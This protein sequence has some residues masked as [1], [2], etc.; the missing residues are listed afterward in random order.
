[1]F[2]NI[3][4]HWNKKSIST[5]GDIF[6]GNTPSKKHPEYYNEASVLWVKPSDLSEFKP[7]I[8]DTEEKLS[9]EGSKKARILPINSVLVTC[10]GSIGKVGMAP[11]ELATNQQINAVSFDSSQVIPKF[12]YYI[13]IYS[14][15]LLESAASKAVVPILN[16]TQF[17]NIKIPVPPTLQE[18]EEIVKIL[19]DAAALVQARKKCIE[20]TEELTP[21]IFYEMFGD[22]VSNPNK[23]SVTK[24]GKICKVE[25]GSTPSRKHPEYYQ[26]NIP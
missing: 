22:P 21:A 5:L 17:G 10:I 6:T 18:Q 13:F 9:I 12:G 11:V 14:K 2:K 19:D 8:W 24:V 20:H 23:Y 7:W 15:T 26:G 1:M 25:T 16:K 3:P 4:S